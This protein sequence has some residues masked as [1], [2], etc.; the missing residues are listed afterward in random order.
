[1]WDNDSYSDTEAQHHTTSLRFY[2][3]LSKTKADVKNHTALSHGPDHS[4]RLSAASPP[5]KDQSP[6]H[7]APKRTIKHNCMCVHEEWR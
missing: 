7:P 3:K 5:H 2:C 4:V 1:M 6:S